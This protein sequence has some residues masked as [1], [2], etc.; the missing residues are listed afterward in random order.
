MLW[1]AVT[2]GGRIGLLTGPEADD[3]WTWIRV[4]GSLVVAAGA[5]VALFRP[6]PGS[7]MLLGVYAVVTTA[8]WGTSLV[9]VW[10][11]DHETA[12]RVVHTVLALVSFAL[13]AAAASAALNRRPSSRS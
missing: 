10:T 2:W 5:G 8:V 11:T 9:S 12:F 7:R 6:V 13:A 3:P 4:L 1:A